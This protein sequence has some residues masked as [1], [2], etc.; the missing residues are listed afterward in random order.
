MNRRDFV[1]ASASGAVLV[2]ASSVSGRVQAASVPEAAAMGE[3]GTQPPIIPTTGP[4]YKSGG[5]A[6]WLDLALAGHGGRLE[7]VPPR[8]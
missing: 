6:E 5:D 8:G 1:A 4:D 7:G 3:V 2:G